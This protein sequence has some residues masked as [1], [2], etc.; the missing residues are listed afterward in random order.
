MLYGQG[1]GGRG[2]SGV[3]LGP[4]STLINS[5]LKGL[6]GVDE[7]MSNVWHARCGERLV[8]AAEIVVSAAGYWKTRPTRQCDEKQFVICILPNLVERGPN[9]RSEPPT[10]ICTSTAVIGNEMGQ[11]VACAS[12]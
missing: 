6:G 9:S 3:F 2:R 8:P 7:S 4:T 5:H 11:L 1:V 12:G 10:F